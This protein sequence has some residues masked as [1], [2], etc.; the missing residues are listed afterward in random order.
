[1]LLLFDKDKD[2]DRIKTQFITFLTHNQNKVSDTSLLLNAKK[3]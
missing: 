2:F 1:M 3:T